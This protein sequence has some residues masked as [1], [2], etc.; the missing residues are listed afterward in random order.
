MKALIKKIEKLNNISKKRWL[1]RFP[2]QFPDEIWNGHW[3]REETLL[4]KELEEIPE[5]DLRKAVRKS[6]CK[7]YYCSSNSHD[8]LWGLDTENTPQGGGVIAQANSKEECI[9]LAFEV[10]GINKIFI[11]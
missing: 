11:L 8:G 9:K 7:R 3:H 10:Y 4:L 6:G 5:R 1:S 2:S